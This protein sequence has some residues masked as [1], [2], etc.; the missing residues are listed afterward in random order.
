[1]KL[2]KK[3]KEVSDLLL[4]FLDEVEKCLN[5]ADQ[6]IHAYFNGTIKEAKLLA[7]SVREIETEVD[8]FKYNIRDKLY[9]GAYL[10]LIREDIYKLVES[11]DKVANAAEACC[12]FLLNQRPSIPDDLKP[13]FTIVGQESMSIIDP[14][15]KAVSCFL[16]KKCSMEKVRQ[17]AQEVGFLESD[18]DKSEWDLTKAIFTSSL[19]FSHKIHLKNCLN[20][21][22]EVSDRAEDAADQLELVALKSMA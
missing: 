8:V 4:K 20:S 18:V 22:V 1:M 2:F 19:A 15:K 21:I 10:P 9:Y 17:Y 14:L 3:E 6:T 5:K 16:R 13:Q 7:R 11:I 12:D